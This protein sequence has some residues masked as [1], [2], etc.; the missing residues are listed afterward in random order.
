MSWKS[1]RDCIP[2]SVLSFSLSPHP[3]SPPHPLD[4]SP[5]P[6]SL[7]HKVSLIYVSCLKLSH[8]RVIKDIFAS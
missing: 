5:S 3:H 8:Y 4:F 6:L 1:Q 2:Y 7:P